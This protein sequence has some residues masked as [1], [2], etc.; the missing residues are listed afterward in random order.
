MQSVPIIGLFFAMT[1][2]FLKMYL[3]QES[4]T[5]ATMTKKAQ[6]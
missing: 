3:Q 1:G 5:V 2:L 4:F 6:K